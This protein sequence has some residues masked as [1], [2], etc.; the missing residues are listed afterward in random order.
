[1]TIRTG[2]GFRPAEADPSS[3]DRRLLGVRLEAR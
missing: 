3:A 1:V 2:R